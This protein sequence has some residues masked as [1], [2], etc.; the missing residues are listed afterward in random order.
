MRGPEP[1]RL[2]EFK[3]ARIET[4]GRSVSALAV[5]QQFEDHKVQRLM[6][7]KVPVT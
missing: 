4:A 3:S 7:Y 2:D 1:G 5:L 6:V